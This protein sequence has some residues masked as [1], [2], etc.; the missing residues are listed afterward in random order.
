ML[1]TSAKSLHNK[2]NARRTEI[3]WMAMNVLFSTNTLA[4]RAEYEPTFIAVRPFGMSN[5]GCS[6]EYPN[7]PLATQEA[8]AHTK[9]QL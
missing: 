6:V 4:S 2:Q 3:T 5:R 7:S 8:Q 9:V 1:T